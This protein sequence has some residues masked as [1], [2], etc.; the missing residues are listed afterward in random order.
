[1]SKLG[2]AIRRSQRVESAPMGFAAARPAPKPTMLVGLINGQE[3]ELN[4]AKEA[5]ADVIIV[6][7]HGHDVQL[8][9]IEKLE[10]TELPV[11][12]TGRVLTVS[13]ADL[14]KA[15]LDF[16]AFE[17]D[18]TPAT[19]LLEE[20][21]GFV[22]RLPEGA[23]ESYLRSLETISLEAVLIA[24]PKL[25]LTA[26]NQIELGRLAMLAHR[27]LICSVDSTISKEDL[28]C[29]RAAGVAVVLSQSIDGVKALKA[30]VATL[31]ARKVHKEEQRTIV[32]LPRGAATAEHDD[33]DDD[34]E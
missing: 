6:D 13:M 16:L 30:T 22:V 15:G 5:G 23:D 21:L 4:Q 29:L 33:D 32:S 1:M 7:R 31:P 2:D 24:Q 20:D 18:H 14:R 3:A 26:A 11:G 25:P 34:D 9:D 27:P 28:Q 8:S 12:I 10:A 17:P 19:A